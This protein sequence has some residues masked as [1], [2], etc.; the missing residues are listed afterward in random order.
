MGFHH[1]SFL[2]ARLRFVSFFYPPSRLRQAQVM[3][4]SRI[5]A[6][7]QAANISAARRHMPKIA[8]EI[9][10]SLHAPRN[11]FRQQLAYHLQQP[12]HI[13]WFLH[14]RK[15]PGGFGQVSEFGLAGN[16]DD[17][18]ERILLRDFSNG[19]PPL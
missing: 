10:D 15:S 13:D 12:G 11:W 19:L 3:E 7:Q 14:E 16:H 17:G 9:A 8:D 2:L 5:A 1:P 4:R 18:Q 6:V